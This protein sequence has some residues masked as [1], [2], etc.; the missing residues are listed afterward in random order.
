M[1]LIGYIRYNIK[2]E[3]LEDVVIASWDRLKTY[4]KGLKLESYSDWRMFNY[5][6]QNRLIPPSDASVNDYLFHSWEINT[7]KGYVLVV[8]KKQLNELYVSCSELVE[9]L[10][11]LDKL[12]EKMGSYYEIPNKIHNIKKE[13]D[14]LALRLKYFYKDVVE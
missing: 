10:K 7:A 4:Y 1:G 3:E 9:K 8:T 5:G 14:S 2:A 11:E 13:Y 12:Y 6:E